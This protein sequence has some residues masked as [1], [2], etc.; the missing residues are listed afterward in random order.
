M[1]YGE[2][3]KP[4]RLA[5]WYLRLNGYL[6]WE[7]FVV[8]PDTGS[9]QR[10]DA[11]IVGVRFKHREDTLDRRLEDDPAIVCDDKF[12]DVVITE[13]KRSQCALN[14]P[15]T[16]REDRNVD[17][18]LKALGCFHPGQ[19]EEAARHIYERG[20]FHSEMVSCRLLAIGERPGE[21][22]IP[23]EQ[24]LLFPRIIAFTYARL[25]TFLRQKSS[26]SNWDPDGQQLRRFAEECS[27]SEEFEHRVRAYFRLDSFARGAPA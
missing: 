22:A 5:Y 15:W 20:K 9:N 23:M 6:V 17:R 16:R 19:I 25:T 2:H 26:V 11:D 1:P 10:T 18:V 13:V 7:N 12:V 24:Q 4:D 3:S 27:S 21:L 8:H 14:G